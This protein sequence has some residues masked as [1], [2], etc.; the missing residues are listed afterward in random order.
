MRSVP[1]WLM[2][3]SGVIFSAATPTPSTL[4]HANR[5]AATAPG[6]G[7]ASP[8]VAPYKSHRPHQTLAEGAVRVPTSE[9]Q[10]V[11]AGHGPARDCRSEVGTT[12]VHPRSDAC[13]ACYPCC[14]ASL[15]GRISR[16]RILSRRRTFRRKLS[17]HAEQPGDHFHRK[18]RRKVLHPREGDYSHSMVPGGLLVMSSTTRLTSA[19]SLVMRVEMPSS[20]S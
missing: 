15:G 1:V 11:F 12:P 9:R 13:G 2:V 6:T 16:S 14:A 20:T 7:P 18:Q 17:G 4:N 19:T 10:H 8:H 3:F 5:P